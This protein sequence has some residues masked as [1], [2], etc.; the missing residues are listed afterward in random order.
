VDNE[1]IDNYKLKISAL[2]NNVNRLERRLKHTTD[3][4]EKVLKAGAREINKKKK[5]RINNYERTNSD[6]CRKK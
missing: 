1:Y 3:K 2:E 5:Q 6:G 4:H